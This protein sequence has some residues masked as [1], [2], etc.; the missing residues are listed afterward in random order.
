M[1]VN[2]LKEFFNTSPI[3]S[4]NPISFINSINSTN[5]ISQP[6]HYKYNL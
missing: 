4:I 3:S 2:E 6:P 1:I 5:P